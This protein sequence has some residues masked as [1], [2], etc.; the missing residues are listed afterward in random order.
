L[1]PSL[2]WSSVRF[3]LLSRAACMDPTDLTLYAGILIIVAG[4]TLCEV[5]DARTRFACLFG[6]N[7]GFHNN[8]RISSGDGHRNRSGDNLGKG[9]RD[10]RRCC[11]DTSRSRCVVIIHQILITLA[12]D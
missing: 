1:L 8:G 7:F 6:G 11:D 3:S 12:S 9:R 4:T 5:H 2:R 10:W